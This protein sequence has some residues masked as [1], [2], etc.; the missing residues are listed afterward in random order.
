MKRDLI[1]KMGY[2]KVLTQRMRRKLIV[3]NRNHQLRGLI[4]LN[5]VLKNTEP[6]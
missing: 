3:G 4:T 6:P 1:R 2:A 5:T